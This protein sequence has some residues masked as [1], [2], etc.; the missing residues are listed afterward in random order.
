[1]NRKKKNGS[2]NGNAIRS[3][4]GDADSRWRDCC[5]FVVPP[6]KSKEGAA[7]AVPAVGRKSVR[8]NGS[9]KRNQE[10]GETPE[11]GWGG[12]V[13]MCNEQLG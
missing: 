6:F 2:C 1:M 13:P 9:I 4:I 3:S 7:C 12:G 8:F 5:W 10:K 11:K